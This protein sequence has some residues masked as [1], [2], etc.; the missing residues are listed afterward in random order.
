MKKLRPGK[1]KSSKGHDIFIHYQDRYS[2]CFKAEAINTSPQGVPQSSRE[3]TLTAEGICIDYPEYNVD[4]TTHSS[5]SQYD[6]AA[7]F[8]SII[9]ELALRLEHLEKQNTE[10]KQSLQTM[11]NR[12]KGEL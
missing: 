1:Y 7:E 11:A 6:S 3:I 2:G 9:N 8:A 5:G 4:P 10:I 12:T